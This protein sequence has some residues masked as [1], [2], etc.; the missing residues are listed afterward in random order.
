MV[1]NDSGDSPLQS[2]GN[3]T[4]S[5]PGNGYL[6]VW[7]SS[8]VVLERLMEDAGGGK[9]SPQ[10]IAFAGAVR[11]SGVQGSVDGRLAGIEV[12]GLKSIR[13]LGMQIPKICTQTYV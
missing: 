12:L 7:R 9:P 3:R 13:I 2:L 6:T 10:G 1:G 8:S 11:I 5:A 4:R